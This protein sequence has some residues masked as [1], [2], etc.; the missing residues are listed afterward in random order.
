MKL[1][2]LRRSADKHRASATF[3]LPIESPEIPMDWAVDVLRL[4]LDPAWQLEEPG[5]KVKILLNLSH[6]VHLNWKK[7]KKSGAKDHSS[8]TKSLVKC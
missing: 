4:E 3:S 6:S 8:S 2:K 7:K 1:Q 5:K